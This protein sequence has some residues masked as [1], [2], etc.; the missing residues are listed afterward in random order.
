MSGRRQHSIT[1]LGRCTTTI[2][3]MSDGTVLV[4]LPLRVRCFSPCVK[5]SEASKGTAT[6]PH[7]ASAVIGS[8][9]FVFYSCEMFQIEFRDERRARRP[10]TPKTEGK[11]GC[12]LLR[13]HKYDFPSHGSA[14]SDQ[15]Q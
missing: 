10:K 8:N 14:M 9:H 2:V 4:I 15:L 3:L 1:V 5:F 7:S 6:W 13:H 12:S 11:V